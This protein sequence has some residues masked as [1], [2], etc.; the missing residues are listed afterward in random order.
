METGAEGRGRLATRRNANC[1]SC[2]SAG[3]QLAWVDPETGLSFCYLT[4][5]LDANLLRQWRRDTSLS[6]KAAV[7]AG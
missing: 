1:A 3:G 7:C 5:G 2:T 4:N 6:S